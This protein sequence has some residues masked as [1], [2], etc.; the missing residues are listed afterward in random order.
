MPKKNEFASLIPA[1]ES[2]M[3]D[4]IKL[5][6]QALKDKDEEKILHHKNSIAT[7]EKAIADNSK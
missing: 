3:N 7:I 4:H 2:D 6:E 1:W 5:L